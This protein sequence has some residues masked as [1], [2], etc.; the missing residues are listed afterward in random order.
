M[1]FR[2]EGCQQEVGWVGEVREVGWVGEVREVRE[3]G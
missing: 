3:V 1:T 2:E